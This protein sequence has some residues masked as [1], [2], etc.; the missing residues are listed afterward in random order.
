M[1]NGTDE[2]TQF[3]IWTAIVAAITGIYGFF[4]RHTTKHPQQS[5][6]D[7]LW[8]EKQNISECAQIVKRMDGNHKEVREDL[9]EIKQLM[10]FPKYKPCFR[11]IIADDY[12]NIYIMRMIII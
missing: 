7:N 8:K 1:T 4:L 10:G 11:S 12:G 9:K 3:F 2:K 6:I 5:E